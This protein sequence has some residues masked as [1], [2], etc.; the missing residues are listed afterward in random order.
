MSTAILNLTAILLYSS[1]GVVLFKRLISKQVDTPAKTPVLW[2]CLSAVAT[3]ALVIYITLSPQ[4][5][6][7]MGMTNA[8]SFI[9][10]AVAL[11]F[12]VL[13]FLRP[14]ENLGVAVMPSAAIAVLGAWLWP[15]ESHAL[16][17]PSRQFT[18]HLALSV[19]A[20]AFLTLA[21]VQAILLSTQERRLRHREPGRVL[22]ALPP[23]QTMETLL[24][25][26][27]GIGFI[28][29]TLTLVSGAIYTRSLLAAV[30]AAARFLDEV[31]RFDMPGFQPR[32]AYVREMQRYGVLPPGP[33][34][35]EAL[36]PYALDRAY[37]RSLWYRPPAH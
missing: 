20:Y 35:D 9:A 34:P 15:A 36:D 4:D 16:V 5:Q 26:L 13:A 19:M 30:E 11:I 14:I 6:W 33:D 3:H 18:L 32:Q 28:L 23:I 24:F 10:C 1:A 25:L 21:V 8:F 22:K 12:T 31:K 2:L 29:L 17:T 27:T 37:W 7:S